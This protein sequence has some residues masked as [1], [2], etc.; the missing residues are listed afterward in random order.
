[1]LRA[2]R[3]KQADAQ[4]LTSVRFLDNFSAGTRGASSAEHFL[5]TGRYAVIF[6]HRQHSLQPFSRHYSHSTHSFLD[7]MDL[8]QDD[9]HPAVTAQQNG[10]LF[11]L[12]SGISA[13]ASTT[14]QPGHPT[15]NL[16]LSEPN[17]TPMRTLLHSYKLV[18]S[19]HLLHSLTFTTVQEYLFLLRGVSR[20]MALHLGPKALY[21]LAAAVSDFFIPQQKL[22][23]LQTGS[24]LWRSD[25]AYLTNAE[26]T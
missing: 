26:R 15:G 19:R 25:S 11:P 24:L 12:L 20:L 13:P 1:M 3:K 18:K 16:L 5:R 6:M 8:P 14:S 17:L 7:L 22:V 23:R 2:A 4:G 9:Q 10:N 21:Y